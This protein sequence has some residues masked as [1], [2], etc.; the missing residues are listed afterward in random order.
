[1]KPVRPWLEGVAACGLVIYPPVGVALFFLHALISDRPSLHRCWLWPALLVLGLWI[2]LQGRL[3]LWLFTQAGLALLL[4]IFVTINSARAVLLGIIAGFAVIAVAGGFER[5]LSRHLWLDAGS[6]Q[7]FTDKLQ[8]VTQLSG[9]S[10]GWRRNGVRLSEKTWRLEPG[11]DRLKLSFEA[12]L[13]AGQ[14]GWQWYTNNPEV[15]QE[16]RSEA[17][18]Q[19]TRIVSPPEGRRDVVQ[20]VRTVGAVAGRTFRVN[21][22]L[23]APEPVMAEGCQGLQLR[24]FDAPFQHCESVSLS[25]DWQ[26]FSIT[27]TFPP[28][29]GQPAL[30][31]RINHI[32]TPSFDV[33]NVSFEELA[34]D[35]WTPLYP[36]EPAGLQVR[37]PLP[38]VHIFSHPALNIVPGEEW[39]RYTLAIEHEALRELKQVSFLLQLEVGVDVALRD[40]SLTSLTPDARQPLPSAFPRFDLWYLQANLA[41]HTFAATGLLLL[42][43]ARSSWVGLGGLLIVLGAIF[44]TGSRAAWLA[45]LAGLPWLL[46]LGTQGRARLLAFGSLG[47]ITIAFFLGVGGDALGRLQVW[48]AEDGNTVP[49]T[50]IWNSAWNTLMAQ[51]WTGVGEQGFVSAWQAQ[52]PDDRREVPTHAHNFWLQFGAAY[53]IP[54]LLAALWLSG[55]LLVIAWRWGRWRGL[56]LVV[57]VLI[58]QVFDYTLFYAGVLFPLILGLN[59]LRQERSKA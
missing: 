21:L 53:G 48:Q 9:D 32:A 22:E 13:T 28:E 20:R 43:L 6:P 16:L 2:L 40:I 30:E 4:A 7:T 5:E 49:R 57:P 1:M 39:Q 45:A 29:A 41:G 14:P 55:G 3:D 46:W 19:F 17:G 10:P 15:Q 23:R 42:L 18:E 25:E 34:G 27:A 56:G 26:R 8:G 47:M 44:L 50:E 52:H 51:P 24:T 54:G 59:M 12:R 11:T 37:L 58:M 38:D 36:V 31:L 35:G 33:R